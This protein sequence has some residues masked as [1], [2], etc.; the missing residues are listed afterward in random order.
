MNLYSAIDRYFYQHFFIPVCSTAIGIFSI[1][2]ISCQAPRNNPLDPLNPDFN[3]GSIEGTVQKIKLP[4]SGIADVIV[5]WERKNLITKTDAEGKFRLDNIPI[6]DGKLIFSKPG[7]KPDTLQIVWGTAKRFFSQMFLNEIPVVEDIF[8]YSIVIGQQAELFARVSIKDNDEDIETVFIS[9]PELPLKKAM[10]FNLNERAYETRL[11][12]AEMNMSDIE[13]TVG[14]EFYIISKD[15][16]QNEFTIS[17]SNVKRIIKN[18]VTGLIPA[19]NDTISV[20]PFLLQWNQFNA[21]YSFSYMIEIFRSDGG[22]QL[23]FQK[24]SIDSGSASYQVD[25]TLP[26]GGDYYWVIWVVDQYQNRSRS[27]TAAFRIR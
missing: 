1:V 22:N 11:T 5:S 21:G 12:L 18:Q 10:T 24:D 3:L 27:L 14:L 16:F 26:V 17:S 13:Q 6:E 4:Y 8:L 20:Q 23:V 9:V 25:E 2:F 19:N 15:I 7:Y